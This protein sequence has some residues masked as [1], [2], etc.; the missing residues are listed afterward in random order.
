M[1]SDVLRFLA[2]DAGISFISLP[3]DSAEGARLITFS[4]KA[5]AFQVLETLCKS[6]GLALIPDDGIWFIRPANDRELHGRSYL[7]KF[8][9]LE[10]VEKVNNMGAGQT[11]AGSGGMMP[12]AALDL[13]GAQESF[14]TLPS[15]IINDIRSILDLGPLNAD[16]TDPTAAAGA[17]GAA[18]PLAGSPTGQD[19]A[20]AHSNE[21]SATH[22]PKIIWKSDSNTLYVVAT[23]LQHLWVEGYLEAADK[24]QPMIAI[25]VKFIETASDPKREFGIDWS[26]TLGETGTFRQVES[27]DTGY[28]PATGTCTDIAIGDRIHPPA[29]FRWWFS[30]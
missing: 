24:S 14:A 10:R 18:G 17:A 8:N 20:Q 25:E 6:N 5:S 27:Y 1:L 30:C 13:Q 22:K 11:G 3:D 28:D 15:A 7:I 23:R 26:G 19:P 29:E 12:I 9:A 2:T 4:I 21:L 16:G